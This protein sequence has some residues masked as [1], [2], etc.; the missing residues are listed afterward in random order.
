MHEVGNLTH[1]STHAQQS[2]LRN[3]ATQPSGLKRQAF[4][5][6]ND[7][8][9]TLLTQQLPT[10]VQSRPWCGPVCRGRARPPGGTGRRGATGWACHSAAQHAA[11]HSTLQRQ[12]LQVYGT[13]FG[14]AKN[15]MVTRMVSQLG[16]C[17]TRCCS[18]L[19]KSQCP[20]SRYMSPPSR[21]TVCHALTNQ[22]TDLCVAS[23]PGVCLWS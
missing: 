19:V 23:L 9:A 13:E 22:R 15:L 7:V 12:P 18:C 3:S 8:N 2:Q 5:A 17:R 6:Q 1:H 16:S 21:S 20:D 11:Q 4:S 14:Q 10:C